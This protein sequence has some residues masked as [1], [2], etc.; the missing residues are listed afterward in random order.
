[1]EELEGLKGTWGDDAG[2]DEDAVQ[3]QVERLAAV[4]QAS[5]EHVPAG[6][7]VGTAW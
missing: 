1:M 6:R 2:D 5:L 3:Q 4:L 7:E